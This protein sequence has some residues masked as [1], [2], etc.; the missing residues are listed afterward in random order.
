MIKLNSNNALL[1]TK[2]KRVTC[3]FV[4]QIVSSG[5]K[6]LLLTLKPEDDSRNFFTQSCL[7]TLAD[8]PERVGGR[9]YLKSTGKYTVKVRVC[10]R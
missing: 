10:Y 4:E 3:L 7:F 1:L 2:A 5:L 8:W 9:I 6:G